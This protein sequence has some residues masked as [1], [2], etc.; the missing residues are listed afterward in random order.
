V[1]RP[2]SSGTRATFQKYALKGAQEATGMALTQDSSGTV[3]QT[4]AD[5]R[6]AIGYLALSYVD[7]S[8]SALSIDGAAPTV[9]NI[10]SGKYPVWSYEHMYTKGKP[11]GLTKAFLD[12]MLTPEV[13]NKLIPSLGYIPIS[14][15][16][17]S[18]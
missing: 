10:T 9:A 8:I 16:K 6:G 15:M 17:V 1:T 3:R 11:S 14:D 7:N 2:A 13:Q 18:R 5:T 12:Y 4:L